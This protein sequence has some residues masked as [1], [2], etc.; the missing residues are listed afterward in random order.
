MISWIQ[1]WVDALDSGYFR[2]T[3]NSLNQWDHD[4]R[5]SALGVLCEILGCNKNDQEYI[6]RHTI[7]REVRLNFAKDDPHLFDIRYRQIADTIAL[8][9]YTYNSSN[10]PYESINFIPISLTA[11]LNC[12]A[13]LDL[14]SAVR[15]TSVITVEGVEHDPS[16]AAL[17][18]HGVPFKT[19]AAFIRDVWPA[20]TF[21]T[22]KKYEPIYKDYGYFKL[23]RR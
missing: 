16:V 10:R 23:Q 2:Q 14:L 7:E 22:T 1:D 19:I 15:A 17:D 8:R 9:F 12:N 13:S 20:L 6:L 5:Y 4:G 3:Y 11:K 21:K 18:Q